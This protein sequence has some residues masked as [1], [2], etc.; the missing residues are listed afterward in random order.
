MIERVASTQYRVITEKGRSRPY[1]FDML[2]QVPE[3]HTA[4]G[5]G[6]KFQ[7]YLDEETAKG[8]ELTLWRFVIFFKRE[9]VRHIL[10][11]MLALGT[12]LPLPLFMN[13][14]LGW[15]NSVKN[16]GPPFCWFRNFCLD[17]S[18]DCDSDFWLFQGEHGWGVKHS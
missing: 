8:K 14:Y 15:L 3:E 12:E 1:Q 17:F 13:L 4:D 2:F 5:L 16:K 10:W 11:V 7:K 6:K 9:L 18:C